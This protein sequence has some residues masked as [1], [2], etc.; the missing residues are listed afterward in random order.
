MP[1]K[2]WIIVSNRLPFSYNPNDKTYK[3]SSGGLVTAIRGIQTSHKQVW[4]GISDKKTPQSVLK[5]AARDAKMDFEPVH[6]EPDLYDSYYND[7]CN[8]V[9]WP[10]FHYETELVRY[11]ADAWNNYIEVNKVIADK[12][13]Q[14][15]KDTDLVWIHDFHLFLVPEIV[16][17]K[18]P[19]LKIGFFLHI[20]FPSSEVY[21]Q[22][23]V[24]EEILNSIIKCDLI[25]FHDY[26]Y[27]RHFC[28]SV[29]N[30]LGIPSSLLNIE[31]SSHVAHLGVYP[32]SIDTKAFTSKAESKKTK[33]YLEAFGL[34][35]NRMTT[36]LGVDRL[37][38]I[39]GVELKL[40]AFEYLLKNHPEL[41]GKIQLFQ[42]AVPTR[43]D[44]DEYKNLKA[45]VEKLVGKINGEYST[46]S[47]T[48]IK[49]IFNSVKTHELMALYRGSEVLFIT[50]KRDGMNLVCLEYIS[51]QDEKDPGVVVLS[52]FAGAISTLSHALKVN[53][54]DIESTSEA[55][56]EAI[57]MEKEERK[58]RHA[59]M[60]DFLNSYT[61]NHWASS[62]MQELA[63]CDQT[64][65]ITVDLHDKP[66][67]NL[68][69]QKLKGKKVT[70]M[71]DYDGTLVPICNKPEDA[72]LAENTKKLIKK[73]N[74]KRNVEF[75][76]VSGRP[77]DFLGGQFSQSTVYMAAEHGGSFFD[78]SKKKWVSLVSSSKRSWYKQAEKI[79]LDYHQRTPGSL[80]EKKQHALSGHYRNSPTDFGQYNARKLASELE[81]ALSNFPVTVIHG[82]KV[83]EVKAMQANKGF[84][85]NWFREKYQGADERVVL[86]IGDDRT[87]EDLF[88]SLGEED[89][90]I[91][92]GPGQTLANYRL[93]KQE[94]VSKLL[95]TLFN[96]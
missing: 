38:Y 8:D 90:S 1:D 79:I 64:Q 42:I 86:A 53:P 4:V 44:V 47:Y 51:C 57:N 56:L 52:E 24:R 74:T 2:R 35:K 91:K 65:S 33:T 17:E 62:F 45:E 6:V 12:I 46:P 81:S 40:Q 93:G 28:S 83:V 75:V 34:K 54:W 26:S 39:K 32:V 70:L 76:V 69:K 95:K 23:P 10:L 16:K 18:R 59:P 80:V 31:V 27:L 92:V 67:F 77:S 30:I 63:T 5:K 66:D 15:A 43:T 89:I 14:M 19:N 49:Y 73:I 48:P 61:A 87:D 82:K 78:P 20:P 84:F 11:K 71:L 22:L 60:F 68:I 36:I 29:Y 72:V 9:L 7:F 88:D 13:I 58:Q 85:A 50:S 41:R 37:D 3:V 21:R 25:G 94:D 96:G 55:L